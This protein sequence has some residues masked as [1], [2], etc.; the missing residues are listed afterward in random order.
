MWSAPCV[1]GTEL[2]IWFSQLCLWS[3]HIAPN[4]AKDIKNGVMCYRH[5]APNGANTWSY[6]KRPIGYRATTLVAGYQAIN[7]QSWCRS[8][9]G[10]EMPAWVVFLGVPPL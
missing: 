9:S 5:V 3:S 7:E 1:E 8:S 4:G 6:G 2:E 10:V